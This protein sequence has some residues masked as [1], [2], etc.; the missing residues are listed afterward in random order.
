M[1]KWMVAITVS[2][3]MGFL[4]TAPS[5]AADLFRDQ[6]LVREAVEASRRGRFT[7]A[8]YNLR[9]IEIDIMDLRQSRDK[10]QLEQALRKSRDALNDYRLSSYEKQRIMEDCSKVLLAILSDL[11]N[12][13]GGHNPYPGDQR[14][15]DDAISLIQDAADGMLRAGGAIE[16]IRDLRRAEIIL[17]QNAYDRDIQQALNAVRKSLEV[18]QNNRLRPREKKQ[19]LEDCARIAIDAIRS[20]QL[21]RGGHG[22][23]G[24]Y[25][26][27]LPPVNPVPPVIR[28]ETINCG[29]WMR[30]LAQC[31]ASGY[32]HSVRVVRNH[33]NT[34]CVEGQNFGMSNDRRSIWVNNG[35]RAEFQVR[36]AN[37]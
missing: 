28:F 36:L 30:G 35:C 18:M 3:V 1:K 2:L 19:I 6:A 21:Y 7:V 15:L 31:S 9:T 11:A 4:S 29:S 17:S 25:H 27:P 37:Y 8:D 32:V 12:G 26:P 22:G 13:R 5:F 16:I 10:M 14:D 20:S 34:Q 24:G 23:G 33:S